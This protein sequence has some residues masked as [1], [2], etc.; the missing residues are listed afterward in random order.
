MAAAGHAGTNDGL[1]ANPTPFLKHNW[2][3]YQVEALLCKIMITRDQHGALGDCGLITQLYI[4][5]IID[6][7]VF[8][9]RYV[10]PHLQFPWVFN[11]NSRLYVQPFTNLCSKQLKQV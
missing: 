9:Y 7:Y 6:P 8:A 4:I 1:C 3:S 11:I 5:K 10:V 2:F